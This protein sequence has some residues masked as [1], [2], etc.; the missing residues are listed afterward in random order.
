MRRAFALLLL[1]VFVI[2]ACSDDANDT[3]PVA[4]VSFPYATV[5]LDN[6]EESTLVTVEVAETQRQ[7]AEGLAGRSTLAD[8]EGMVFVYFAE[9]DD[10]I[11]VDGVQIP[12]SIAFFDSSGTIVELLDTEACTDD[13]CP[14]YEL[15]G[16]YMGVLQ[17]NR[18]MFDEWGISE[19]DHLQLTR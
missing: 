11:R 5:L 4:G 8:D 1:S 16:P 12:L 13:P 19:G 17:V 15:G 10:A 9:R 6:G 7:Q 2:A 18:G 3:E 14:A